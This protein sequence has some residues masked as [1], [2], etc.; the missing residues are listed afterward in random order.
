MLR[1]LMDEGPEGKG[2]A[3]GACAPRASGGELTG[4][5]ANKARPPYAAHP[6]EL[7]IGLQDHE[8][9]VRF[10]NIWLRRLSPLPAER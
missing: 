6:D 10:R 8:H 4:P 3:A 5:T 7:P 1:T 2:R 9:P